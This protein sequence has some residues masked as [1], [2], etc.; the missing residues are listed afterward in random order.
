MTRIRAL[1]AILALLFIAVAC[2]S[3]TPVEQSA[4]SEVSEAGEAVSQVSE[5]A[6]EVGEE[7]S[8]TSEEVSEVSEEVDFEDLEEFNRGDFSDP[9][10]IDNQWLPMQPGTQWVLEGFTVEDGEEIDHRIEFTVTDLTKV[11]DGVPTV[12]AYIED[13]SDD[14]LVEAEI[15]F[16]AQDDGGNVWYFG[17]HPEEYEDGEFVDAPTWIAS[18][19]DA[20]AG[21]KMK[22]QP[23]LGTDSYS[24]GWAPAV[25]WTDRGQVNKMG[26]Q[27]CVPADCYE[28][29][30]VIDEFNQEE[31]GAFQ[32]KYY[33]RGVG[34]VKVGWKGEDA[35]QEELELVERVQLEPSQ[36]AAVR[37]AALDLEEHAYEIS[38]DVYG[39]TAPSEAPEVTADEY[40]LEVLDHDNFDDPTNIDNKWLPMQ[41]GTQWTFEG[42]T[43]ENG[44]LANHLLIF[45]VTDLI[46]EIDGIPSVVA[47]IEDFSDGGLVEAEIAFYAQ[48]NDGNVW[49]LGEYPEEYD[50]FGQFVD[51]PTWIAG[52]QDAQAGI[53]MPADPQEGM[54]SLSQ[55]FAPVPQ[56]SDRGQVYRMGEHNC[57]PFDCFEEVMIMDE[58][59]LEEP[60]AIQLKYYAPDVGQIRVGFRGN[61]AKP[62]I[63]ELVDWKQLDTNA[64]T[65][66]RDAAL[67][68]EERAHKDHL[69]VFGET[70][71]AESR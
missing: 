6:S 25:E 24:Q 64:L 34:N 29:V 11:I 50:E 55:G 42:V 4:G 57:V 12:V 30:L 40:A 28:D 26:Q 54:D 61:D 23:R 3:S 13:F 62:E 35:Q 49:Y 27:I 8:E 15:A 69:D 18:Q 32:Q 68:L 1:A 36:L 20:Q 19:E 10:H 39:Q 45:T 17:E 44:E 16:Y 2:S 56:W 67:A 31:P 37:Q 43:L 66:V 5:E 53:L 33:A 14:E 65:E 58:F 38:A 63:L 9:T 51:A 52:K 7:I 22:A 59:N 48:D 60:G 47:H 71:L 21:I 41:P 46:K 70:P